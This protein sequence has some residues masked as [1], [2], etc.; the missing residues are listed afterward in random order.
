V[1]RELDL[2]VTCLHDWVRQAGFHPARAPDLAGVTVLFDDTTLVPLSVQELGDITAGGV[3]Y[4]TRSQ[5]RIPADAAV[6]PHRITAITSYGEPMISNG[7][8][9]MVVAAGQ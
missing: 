4:L 2:T 3:I 9:F 7:P 8:D 1:A 5:F 6:G